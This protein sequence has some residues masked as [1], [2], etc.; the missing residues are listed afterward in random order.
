MDDVPSIGFH[1]LKKKYKVSIRQYTGSKGYWIGTRIIFS[2]KNAGYFYKLI[3][4]GRFDWSL[5]KFDEQTLSLGRID[6]C[7]SRPNDWS[8]TSKL[9]DT[10]LVDSRSQIQDHTTTRYMKLHDFPDGKML[11][12]NRRNNS[13]HYRVYQKNER[14][15][16]E[17]ELKHRQTKLVQDYLFHNQ[18]DIFE[19]HLVRQYFNYSGK[20][21]RL[22]YKYTDWIVDF[23][24]RYQGNLNYRSLVTSYLE[25]QIIKQQEEE[26][27]FFHL[28]QF[29]S[30]IKSLGLKP[31]K[32]CKKHRIKKQNYY[33]LKFPLSQFVKFTGI[34]LSNPSDRK[35]LIGYFRQ[36]H[37]LDPIVKEFSDGAFRSYVCFLYA[38]CENPSGKSWV[39]EV[40]AA[41][42]LFSFPYPFQ[43]P[44]S[45][46]ISN[47][48]HDL[49]LKVRLMKSLAVSEREKRLDL[50]EF[51]NPIN[52]SQMIN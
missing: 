43:L 52:R 28:L 26:E 29:L 4:T 23:Q 1:G 32:D 24:R 37:K 45:F 3:Q 15:R 35:N 13:L 17:L 31:F 51:F 27:R 41:E 47:H 49:R 22:D 30:F 8:H 21:L 39:V 18:L 16:F 34:Q 9:F 48:K 10:F 36:L 19:N 12:V 38:E 33:R 2:G 50:E 40:F 46:L 20:V 42:E 14:V 5:L 44:K 25:S 11:K 7:F 6:L